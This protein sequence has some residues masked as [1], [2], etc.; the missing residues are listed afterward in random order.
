MF[1]CMAFS[2][3]VAGQELQKVLLTTKTSQTRGRR[4]VGAKAHYCCCLSM[5]CYGAALHRIPQDFDATL[6]LAIGPVPCYLLRWWHVP[7]KLLLVKNTAM[8]D[9]FVGSYP[10]G[11]DIASPVS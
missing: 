7:A 9:E 4:S 6:M 8:H 3:L 1:S 11:N 5:G 10:G 2:D